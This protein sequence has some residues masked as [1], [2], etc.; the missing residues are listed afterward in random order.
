MFADKI[1]ALRKEKKLTQAEVA[2][3]VGLSARGYQDLELGAK[4]G[5]DNL[6][7]IADFY[8][9]SVDWLM[10]RTDNP[11]AQAYTSQ[12]KEYRTHGLRSRNIRY[13]GHRRGPR[14]Y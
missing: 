2:K 11:H 6:L 8:D 1:R 13:R 3:E 12:R 4:P 7:H 9:V 14:G 10:G 5:F